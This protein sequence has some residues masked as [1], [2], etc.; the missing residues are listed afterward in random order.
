MSLIF[1]KAMA[2]NESQQRIMNQQWVDLQLKRETTNKDVKLLL[3]MTG[4]SGRSPADAYREFDP[5]TKILQNK[6]GEFATMERAMSVSRSVSIGREVFE[7]R[8]ASDQSSSKSSM[9]GQIGINMDHVDYSYAGTVVP[10]H[11]AGYGR[12]W[13]EVES[14]RAEGFDAMIDD[15]RECELDVRRKIND[16]MWNGDAALAMKGF[17][18]L[19]LRND[20]TVASVV[21]GVDLDDIASS[22]QAIQDEVRRVRDI[23]QIANNCD[24]DVRLG[25]S[26]EIWSNWER[27]VSLSD[28]SFGT[29][30]NF[31][32]ELSGISEVYRDSELSDNQIV[33]YWADQMG[34]HPVTGMALSSYAVP[35]QF[36]NDDFNFIKWAAVGFIA[37]NDFNGNKCAIYGAS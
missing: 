1:S 30:L 12:R 2:K 32:K 5:V 24:A 4:N 19:G 6:Q 20:P 3:D 13:R 22:P 36:H 18:W 35:R 9:S 7:Y 16:Y 25:V 21:L 37:K 26:R 15:S 17:S 34:F 14:M 31:V 8:R 27:S 23:L 28:N 33:M 11:D 29:I 10:I